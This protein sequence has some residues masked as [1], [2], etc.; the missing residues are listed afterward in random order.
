MGVGSRAASMSF[1]T[2][3]MSDPD[4]RGVM[5]RQPFEEA[6]P[7]TFCNSPPLPGAEEYMEIL[8][9]RAPALSPLGSA[10]LQPAVH[11]GAAVAI[12]VAGTPCA[13]EAGGLA[14]P[15]PPGVRF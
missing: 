2:N 3:G 5:P 15:V 4:A 1:R 8:P 11:A 6:Q 14:A 10:R 12:D 7:E 9:F 13:L